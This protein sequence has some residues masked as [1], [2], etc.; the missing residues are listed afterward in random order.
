MNRASSRVEEGTSGFLSISEI[1]LVVYANVEQGSQASSCVE[2]R[3][4]A[5]LSSCLWSVRPLVEVY[6]ER[7]AFSRGCNQGVS[8]PSCCDFILLIT[9]EEVPGNQDLP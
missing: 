6:F 4:S 7:V 1:D 3:G 8:A 9:L 5:C 2:A